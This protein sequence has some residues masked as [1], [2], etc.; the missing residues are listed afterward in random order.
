M[1]KLGKTREEAIEDL[2]ELEL[3]LGAIAQGSAKSPRSASEADRAY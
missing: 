3:I 2:G 1:V